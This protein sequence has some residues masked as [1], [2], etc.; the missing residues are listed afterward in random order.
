MDYKT[1]RQK[2]SVKFTFTVPHDEW[3]AEMNA[4]YIKNRGKYGIPG[5]RKGHAPRKMIENAYGPTVFFDD[6]FNACASKGYTTALHENEDVFPVDEPKVDIEKFEADA[7]TF[8]IEVTVKPDVTLGQYKGLTVKKA[9]YPVTDADVEADIERNLQSKSRL[10]EITDR[11]AQTGD[12]V[13]IDYSGSVNGEK[14]TGGTA[15][16]QELT[17]GSHSFIPGFEEQVVGMQIGESKDVSVTFPADYHAEDLKGKDAVFAVTLHGIKFRE[18]PELNDAFVKDTT[19]FET[20]ADYRADV[21]KRLKENAAHREDNE[22]K[23]NMI[24]AIVQNASVEIPACMVESELDYMLQDFE[25]RLSYM[26]G[27]MKLDDYFK[28]TGSSRE[29]FRKDRKEEAEKSVKTR[30]V[31]EAIIKA[32]KTEPTDEEMNARIAEIA[33]TSGKSAEEYNK[34]LSDQQRNHIKSDV[35]VE[36]TLNELVKANTFEVGAG[37]EKTGAAQAEKPAAKKSA[38]AKKSTATKTQSK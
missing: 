29:D 28:Y 37:E 13:T 7:M 6:A 15:E 4:A 16:K 18:V 25:Y 2:G 12:T 22:N 31:L 26:Y 34:T 23:N 30:L 9:S 17:L 36:K 19:K 33:A 38:A 27:G 21:E 3:E 14:F 32:E 11:A 1:E 20:V 8:T 10:T 24:E 5:F 35:T